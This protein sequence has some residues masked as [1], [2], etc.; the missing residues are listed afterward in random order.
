MPDYPNDANDAGGGYVALAW[1]FVLAA[2]A[3]AGLGM[4]R[5][6]AYDSSI[7]S[8]DSLVR[9]DAY[10]MTILVTRGTGYLTLGVLF[11]AVAATFA[12]LSTRQVGLRRIQQSALSTTRAAPPP[13]VADS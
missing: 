2:L 6:L 10:N 13:G 12:V 3:C 4:W 11:A 5:M 1:T 8:S 7:G 9:G